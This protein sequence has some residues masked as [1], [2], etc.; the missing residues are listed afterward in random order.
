MERDLPQL[1]KG[2][3]R[4]FD[5]GAYTATVTIEGSVSTNL[6]SIP[7]SRA[8]DSAE[9]VAGRYVGILFFDVTDASDAVLCAVW[10]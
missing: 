3:L 7:V 9:M 2:V 1:K 5:A 6:G 4:A 10:E 8:I